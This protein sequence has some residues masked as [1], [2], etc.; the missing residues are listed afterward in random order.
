MTED[1]L[2]ARIVRQEM[3]ERQGEAAKAVDFA[4]YLTCPVCKSKPGEACR[5]LNG[6]VA[7]GRPDGVSTALAVAHGLRKRSRRWRQ[8]QAG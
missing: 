4:A 5:A 2:A 7:G 6:R 1:E 8:Q 3:A